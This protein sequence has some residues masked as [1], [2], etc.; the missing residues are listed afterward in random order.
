VEIPPAEATQD[1][2][3]NDNDE[4]FSQVSESMKRSKVIKS[5]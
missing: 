1:G 4:K 3:Q 5:K 2:Q